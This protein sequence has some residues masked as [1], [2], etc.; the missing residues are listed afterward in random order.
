MIDGRNETS[1]FKPLSFILRNFDFTNGS[2]QNEARFSNLPFLTYLSSSGWHNSMN[3]VAR[4]GVHPL[5]SAV[6]SLLFSIHPSFLPPLCH[7]RP[8]HGMEGRRGPPT[9]SVGLSRERGRKDDDRSRG[10]LTI[11]H[12]RWSHPSMEKPFPF[13][14]HPYHQ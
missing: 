10:I 9:E 5:M 4:R 7:L 14:V 12:F 6:D 3:E 2:L 1:Q 13:P 11:R 8:R